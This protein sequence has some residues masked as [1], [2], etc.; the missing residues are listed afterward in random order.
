M[1][2][3][4]IVLLVPWLAGCV[5]LTPVA[6]VP[7]RGQTEDTAARDRRECEAKARAEVPSGVIEFVAAKLAA[8]LVGA[9]LGA[10]MGIAAVTENPSP[11]GRDNAGVKAAAEKRHRAIDSVFRSC[12]RERGDGLEL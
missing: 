6:T 1:R 9:V 5:T 12:M 7:Q 2:V 11:R 10:G 8:P 3:F 4:A